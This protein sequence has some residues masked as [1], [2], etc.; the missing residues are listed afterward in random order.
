VLH[1]VRRVLSRVSGD[2]A[3][4]RMPWFL[5]GRG[6]AP[7]DR[8]HR[9]ALEL[10]WSDAVTWNARAG[11][12]LRTILWPLAA[13]LHAARSLA[14]C[15][16]HV[17]RTQGVGYLRQC[18]QMFV[19]ANFHNVGADAYYAYQLFRDD[20]RCWTGLILQPFEANRVGLQALRRLEVNDI[21]PK[22]PFYKRCRDLGLPTAPVTATFR[23]GEVDE[24]FEG[25]RNRLPLLD[26]VVKPCNAADGQGVEAWRREAG[27]ASWRRGDVRLGESE[28]LDR[29]RSL[30]R[31][32]PHLIQPRL[33]NHGALKVLSSG[34][35]CTVRVVTLFPLER[36][37]VELASVLRMPV[38]GSDVD[39]FNVSGIAAPVDPE[40]GRLGTA[41][42]RDLLRGT[43]DR[44]PDTGAQ[45][46]GTKLP[47]RAEIV[48]LCLE[49]HARFP[50]FRS[51]G[52]DVPLTPNGP[53]LLEANAL[54]G[55]EMMQMVHARP[56]GSTMAP[57][58][59]L[60]GAMGSSRLA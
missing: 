49:A 59:L 44:H 30:S 52:W 16:G 42:S 38:G 36:A 26:L 46:L 5:S 31:H 51:I 55:V 9:L 17:R 37:P 56:L 50:G 7:I 4:F 43:W 13:A 57:A 33:E 48:A 20:R 1:D 11:L 3:P 40:T 15:G 12:L 18:L 23:D 21:D 41:I 28:L 22:V 14:T 24:W 19:C 29:C 45:I 39:N 53:V 32:A 27:S 8:I 2:H 35:L 10:E 54:W 34:A 47:C 58:C 6:G 25:E 60:E